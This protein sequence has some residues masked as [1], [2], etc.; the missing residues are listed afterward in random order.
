MLLGVYEI[1]WPV[2]LSIR[3]SILR[4]WH[5][6]WISWSLTHLSVQKI[7]FFKLR[8]DENEMSSLLKVNTHHPGSLIIT[9]IK[10]T[11]LGTLFSK[12]ARLLWLSDKENLKLF[13]TTCVASKTKC[14]PIFTSFFSWHLLC[15]KASVRMCTVYMVSKLTFNIQNSYNPNSPGS[16]KLKQSCLAYWATISE[17]LFLSFLTA[18]RSTD[19][20]S[21]CLWNSFNLY[22]WRFC[23]HHKLQRVSLTS[24]TYVLQ[25]P[26]TQPSHFSHSISGTPNWSSNLAHF[27]TSITPVTLSKNEKSG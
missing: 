18:S 11:I 25:K 17:T 13:W 8:I 3:R 5:L 15:S 9:I 14:D 7:G 12:T 16:S 4:F 10:T 24:L 26:C 6:N 22:L 19:P 27:A 21:P 2:K 20:A 23:Q 1:L